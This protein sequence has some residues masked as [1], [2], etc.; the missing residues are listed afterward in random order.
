MPVE[1]NTREFDPEIVTDFQER[2][3][4]SSYLDLDGLLSTQRPVSAPN[5]TTNCCSSS[6]TRPPNCG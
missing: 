4:Y 3:S 2:M 6:S 1:H 5:I